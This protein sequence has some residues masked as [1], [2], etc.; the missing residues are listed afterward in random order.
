MKCSGLIC[1]GK[2]DSLLEVIVLIASVLGPTWGKMPTAY[3]CAPADGVHSGDCLLFNILCPQGK[4]ILIRKVDYGFGNP[5]DNCEADF[6]NCI[7][8]DNGCCRKFH[9]DK[10]M[11]F[12]PGHKYS[13]FSACSWKPECRHQTDIGYMDTTRSRFSLL[14][15][16]CQKE[17]P[18]HICINESVSG[19]TVNLI[20]NGSE[21]LD[22]NPVECMCMFETA[23]TTAR[24]TISAPDLRLQSGSQDCSSKTIIS[25]LAE[26]DI[27]CSA[28]FTSTR[29]YTRTANSSLTISFTSRPEFIWIEAKGEGR[30]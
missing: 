13:I 28:S 29:P 22:N 27:N 26:T 10:L 19:K 30:Y 4:R 12:E 14:E 23:K 18:V 15:Y 17:T 20:F 5:P 16:E 11:P 8:R 3:A 6:D 25:G 21:K 7:N 2:V 9:G 24:Y 1:Y